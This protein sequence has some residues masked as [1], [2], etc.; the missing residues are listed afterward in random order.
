MLVEGNPQEMLI[1]MMM[2][3]FEGDAIAKARSY[4]ECSAFADS[5]EFKKKIQEIKANPQMLMQYMSDEQISTFISAGLQRSAPSSMGLSVVFLYAI[6]IYRK[7][8]WLKGEW[9]KL[10]KEKDE[11]RKRER[12]EEKKNRFSI[13]L[14][15]FIR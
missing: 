5:P 10:K 1:N 8:K 12:E 13:F 7:K 4:P 15:L 11:K 14:V 3:Q 6:L 2:G 9:K